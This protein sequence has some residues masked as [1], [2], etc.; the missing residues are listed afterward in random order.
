MTMFRTKVADVY[1]QKKISFISW[2]QWRNKILIK[3]KYVS[4]ISQI[5]TY[6]Y[7]ECPN[8]TAAEEWN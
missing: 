1:W 2:M 4:V 8:Y 6:G 3:E 7:L 5:R